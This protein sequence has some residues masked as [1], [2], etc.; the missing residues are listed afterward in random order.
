MKINID[1]QGD[2]ATIRHLNE[3]GQ[4]SVNLYPAM[5]YIADD[6]QRVM[7]RNF[8]SDGGYSGPMW[9]PLT[10]SW[11]EEKIRRGKN[12]GI[13]Q[14]DQFL[15]RSLTQRNA[16]GAI[17]RVT[18][19]SVERGTRIFYAIFHAEG[20]ERM[21][22]RNFLRIPIWDRQRWAKVVEHYILHGWV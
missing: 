6:F 16:R 17:R 8:R 18:H 12:N 22:R 14:F 7:A 15:V 1:L 11:L 13:L 10:D 19:D 4:R 9:A 3:V 2:R 20:T 5:E 21:P